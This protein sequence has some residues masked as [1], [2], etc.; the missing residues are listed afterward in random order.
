MGLLGAILS[1]LLAISGN[2]ASYRM[3]L[4]EAHSDEERGYIK[5]LF[6]NSLV[7]CL[8]ISAVLAFPLYFVLPKQGK[9]SLFWSMLFCQTLVIYFLTIAGF[10]FRTLAARRRHLAGLLANQYAGKFP[11]S[12]YEYRSRL[13]LLGLPLVHVRLGDRFDVLRGPVKAWIAIG[14]SHAVGVIFA[15][16]GIAIAPLSFGGIA[17][18]LLPFGAMGVGLVSLWRNRCCRDMMIHLIGRCFGAGVAWQAAMGGI[19]SRMIMPSAASPLPR[20]RIPKSPV[21]SSS[22]TGFSSAQK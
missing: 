10:V 14:S 17:I 20:R 3:S 12:A 13:S 5:R 18:G 7:T 19:A 6:R 8:V 22:K 2:Y 4:D 9:A 16:G 1:P 15:S 21:C 11:P